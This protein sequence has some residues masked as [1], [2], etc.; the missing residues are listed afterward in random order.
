MVVTKPI[1]VSNRGERHVQVMPRVPDLI[2]IVMDY[3]YTGVENT[4]GNRYEV[5]ISPEEFATRIDLEKIENKHTRDIVERIFER[6]FTPLSRME[7]VDTYLK[8][9]GMWRVQLRCELSRWDFDKDFCESW[10]DVNLLMKLSD[11]GF[12]IRDFFN[13]RIITR[14]WYDSPVFYGVLTFEVPSK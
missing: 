9:N 8:E 7:H 11:Y 13:V 4:N 6:V 14:P 5:T 2:F 1:R 10:E 3:V 12:G